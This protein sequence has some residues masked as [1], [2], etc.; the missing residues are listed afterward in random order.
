[1]L[2]ADELTKDT[3]WNSLTA[4]KEGHAVVADDELANA[5]SLGTPASMLHALDLLVPQLE[6]ATE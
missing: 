4:V 3:A 1:M 5:I 6:D 2:S